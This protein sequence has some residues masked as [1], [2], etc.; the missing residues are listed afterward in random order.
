MDT[1]TNNKP[2]KFKQLFSS[3]LSL[4]PAEKKLYEEA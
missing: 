1:K 4:K 2:D 3:V